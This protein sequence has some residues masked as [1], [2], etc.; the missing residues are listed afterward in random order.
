[1][2]LIKS[3][4]SDN[5]YAPVG[6]YSAA[7]KINC[8]SFQIIYTSGII[9]LVKSSN[10]L[11]ENIK[12][13]ANQAFT[14]LKFLL[15]DNGVGLNNIAKITIFLTDINDFATVDSLYKTFFDTNYFPARSTVQV[16]KLPKGAK[17]EVEAIC[18]IQTPKF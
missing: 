6:S 7:T 12:D 11:P 1:M 3:I 8:G 5:I 18:Y 17:I 13:Q 16:S 15:N 10:S 9:G 4:Q 2:S 14:N